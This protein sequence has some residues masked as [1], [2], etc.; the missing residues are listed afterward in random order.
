MNWKKIRSHLDGQLEAL[1]T[2]AKRRKNHKLI[3]VAISDLENLRESI[4]GLPDEDDYAPICLGCDRRVENP[5]ESRDGHKAII[6]KRP[7]FT[8]CVRCPSATTETV[9]GGHVTPPGLERYDGK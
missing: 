6:K 9:C 3:D 7:R 5:D 2:V 1:R 4:E 8:T